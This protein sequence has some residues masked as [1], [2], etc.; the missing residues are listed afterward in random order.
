MQTDV[1]A[2][3]LSTSSARRTT[4][5]NSLRKKYQRDFY[6]RPPRGGR[7]DSLTSIPVVSLFL[8]T[9]SARR[10]TLLALCDDLARLF[11]STSSAR[12]TTKYKR[13]QRVLHRISIHV[14]REE[15]D[16][17]K[18]QKKNRT[19]ISI[20]VLREEDDFAGIINGMISGVISIHVLR[21]EDDGHRLCVPLGRGDFYPRPP[22]GGR[23]ITPGRAA[24]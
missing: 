10:T 19:Q 8:S 5:I 20:H 22:R 6:P 17:L 12:R 16:A 21:E 15:D 3:F 13:L 7:Q 1:T 4:I 2:L 23:L 14:L 9:S 18:N 11:L 24:E